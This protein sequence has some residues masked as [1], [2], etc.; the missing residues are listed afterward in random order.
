M[1]QHRIIYSE[2]LSDTMFATPKESLPGEKPADS[3]LCLTNDLLQ[4][5]L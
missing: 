5:T 2:L 1:L 3:Y 4:R